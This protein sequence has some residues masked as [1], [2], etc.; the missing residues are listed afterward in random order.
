MSPSKITAAL[1][2]LAT[3][4]ALGVPVEFLP[5]AALKHD[6]VMTMQGYGTH[7]QPPGTWSD[8]SSLAFCLADSLGGGYDLSDIAGRFVNWRDKAYWTA[9]N[10]VFD[11]GMATSSAIS[12]LRAGTSPLLTGGTGEQDNGNGSLMRILPLIFYLRDKPIEVRFGLVG[13]VSG[14]T[15]RHIQSVFACFVYCEY[16]L[17]LLE[18]LDKH[19]AFGS[20]QQ[21]VNN[22]VDQQTVLP[23]DE[24][25]L[26]DRLLKN[27]ADDDRSQSIG[28][29][30]E[31]EIASSGYVLHTLEASLWCFLTTDTYAEA[32]LRAV[33]LG[34]D[35]DTTGCVTGG[36]AGLYY[37]ADSIPPDWLDALAR[38]DDIID[39]GNR[40]S[41]RFGS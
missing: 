20:M 28:Q 23:D 3:G 39:L 31:A 37:G 24:R 32:V 26:F 16:A 10:R 15:H 30:P 17:L 14:I 4:D 18:G 5:R 12:R 25:K 13:E 11:I 27:A 41:G 7:Q 38:K 40:L 33:N 29:Y 1:L 34:H 36:L 21:R 22:F 8:D 6:P 19:A 2:G 9:H 35:T